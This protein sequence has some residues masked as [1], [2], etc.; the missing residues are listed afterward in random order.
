M[1]TQQL[2]PRTMFD[3]PPI[4]LF[5]F[6]FVIVILFFI[7]YFFKN[8]IW[9]IFFIRCETKKEVAGFLSASNVNLK[10]KCECVISLMI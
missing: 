2:V 4:C 9:M 3:D 10:N 8:I 5:A 1:S 6:F 7:K